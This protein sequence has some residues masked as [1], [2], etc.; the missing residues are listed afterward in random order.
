MSITS[1]LD[2]WYFVILHKYNTDFPPKIH[3]AVVNTEQ[4]KLRKLHFKTR[5]KWTSNL[6]VF[7]HDTVHCKHEFN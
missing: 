2:H 7:E 4:K 5:H 3:S 6:L 1:D